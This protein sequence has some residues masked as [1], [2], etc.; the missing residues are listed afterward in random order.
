M[1]AESVREGEKTS[2]LRKPRNEATA[3]CKSHR[4]S[5]FLWISSSIPDPEGGAL[6]DDALEI[7]E[8]TEV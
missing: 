6:F 3:P 1:R 7:T 4:V 8:Q 5:A 2:R